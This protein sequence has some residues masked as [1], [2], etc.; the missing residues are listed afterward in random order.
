MC[1]ISLRQAQNGK[2]A[3][4]KLKLKALGL[5]EIQNKWIC[6]QYETGMQKYR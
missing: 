3:T 6:S 2:K 5:I 4:S 1:I